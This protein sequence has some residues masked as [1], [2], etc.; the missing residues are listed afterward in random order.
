MCLQGTD[1][2]S[3]KIR[4]EFSKKLRKIRKN[5]SVCEVKKSLT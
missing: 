5:R 3:K 1:T 2:A 4:R